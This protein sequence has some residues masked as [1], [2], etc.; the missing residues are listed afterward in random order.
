M[1]LVFDIESLGVDFKNPAWVFN[2]EPKAIT[3]IAAVDADTGEEY[4][5]RHETPGQIEAGLNFLM[6]AD[7]L[8]GHNIHDF[9]IPYIQSLYPWFYPTGDVEDSKV[10]SEM[11]YPA[12]DLRSKDFAAEKKYRKWIAKRLYGK[13]SLEAWGDRLG[14]P[15]D[16]F[17][18]RITALKLDP[19]GADLPEPYATERAHYCLQD[20]KTNLKLFQFFW[21][22][23]DYAA[24]AAVIYTENRVAQIL[25]RQTQWGVRF[26]RDRAIALHKELVH[27]Q[28]ELFKQLVEYFAPFYLRDGKGQIPKRTARRF[29]EN[30]AGAKTRKYKGTVQVGWYEEYT[31]DC[32]FVKVKLTEF[33]PNSRQ[34]IANRLMKLYGWKPTEM[35]DTGQPKVD[36]KVLSDLRFP[37]VA[38]LIEYMLVQK[39]IG[40]VADG[41]NAWLKKERN[42]RIH[43]RVNQNGTRTTRASHYDPNLGQVP[44]VK[45]PYGKQCR[46]CFGASDDREQVGCDLSGIE[47]RALGH[48]LARYDGGKY[49]AAVIDGDVH[50]DAKVACHFNERDNVKTLE[51]AFLYGAFDYK[52]GI[53][54]LDDMTPE[55]RKEFG[56]ATRKAVTA[57]GTQAR[58]RLEKGIN[59]LEPLVRAVHAAAKN[60]RIKTVAG[61]WIA[62]P[63]QHSALN[64]VLQ[65]L[66]GELSKVWMVIVD[67]MLID[68]GIN[69]PNRW[70]ADD[71]FGAIQILYVHDEL[72]FDVKPV[73]VEVVESITEQAASAAGEKL[74]LR[75]RVDAEAKHGRSWAECH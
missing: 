56:K 26:H 53:T 36:E 65:S 1:R 57:L 24:N 40:Q 71:T 8:G 30:P 18:A 29:V 46:S 14:E 19:W 55:Q 64:T 43:G 28:D 66:G 54:M 16:D 5:W 45:K 9:D 4:L 21:K 51:Y 52:L 12:K 33:N 59:G 11:W 74:N 49:A 61:R 58:S 17:K 10:E 2:D 23:F 72:Q 38:M 75:V 39:R 3:C 32:M 70:I 68:A 44:K 60:K 73:Y 69:P 6:A 48:Y 7:W 20:V 22:K 37:P 13:H 27:R 15:K 42:G 67:D 31:E 47:L 63:S 62:C 34:H 35:T 25:T 50:E 41:D